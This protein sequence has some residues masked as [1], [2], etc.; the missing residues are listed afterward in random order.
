[1]N[2][3]KSRGHLQNPYKKFKVGVILLGVAGG[4]RGEHE[5]LDLE[6]S[7]NEV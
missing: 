6:R 7:C 4:D 5:H 1:M 3:M 2:E